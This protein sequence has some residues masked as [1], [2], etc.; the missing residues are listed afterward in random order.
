[1]KIIKV[2]NSKN[3]PMED[4]ISKYGKHFTTKLADLLV[5][6]CRTMMELKYIGIQT[7]CKI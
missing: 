1:M 5:S 3:S 7:M 2:I 6:K 4:Y